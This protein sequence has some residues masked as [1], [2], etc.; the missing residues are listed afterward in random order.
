MS[1]DELLAALAPIRL[2]GAMR[3]LDWRE[4][5]ALF[6]LGLILAAVIALLLMPLLSRKV[7]IRQRI[8]ATRGLPIEE[9]L[10]AVSR[11]T[12]RLPPA[13]RDTAYRRNSQITDDQIERVS[14]ARR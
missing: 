2:P 6:G 7:S 12:G 8:R 9:R 10:L 13:L 11:I 14:G 4:L 3:G 5:L 1:R